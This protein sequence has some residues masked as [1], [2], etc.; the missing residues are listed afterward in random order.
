MLLKN[1]GKLTVLLALAILA[2]KNDIFPETL[3]ELTLTTIIG[4]WMVFATLFLPEPWLRK[5]GEI[6][7]P[8]WISIGRVPI[9]WIAFL[10]DIYLVKMWTIW[11]VAG[12]LLKDSLD[13]LVAKAGPEAEKHP[14]DGSWRQSW[15]QLMAQLN[16]NGT[17]QSGKWLDPFCDKITVPLMLLVLGGFHRRRLL[18]LAIPIMLIDI[19]GQLM[20]PPLQIIPNEYIK[21]TAATW[22]GKT[23]FVCQCVS[24]LS[25]L[26]WLRPWLGRVIG[27]LDAYGQVVIINV[28]YL[29]P[30]IAAF[31]ALIF[32]ALSIGSRLDI[33]GEQET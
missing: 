26:V 13:G 9:Q 6:C 25:T 28:I 10:L 31:L 1:V 32:G 30:E 19:F 8:N 24:F 7:S 16:W 15:A 12:S 29:F 20:R 14:I 2:T 11:L 27:E 21:G 22:V 17:S 5:I 18:L 33:Y 23:K 3:R 4:L